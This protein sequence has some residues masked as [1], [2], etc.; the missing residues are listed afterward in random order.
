MSTAE[1]DDEAQQILD[2]YLSSLE[3]MA[4]GDIDPAD[5]N[6]RIDLVPGDPD[7]ESLQRSIKEF[8]QLEPLIWNRATRRLVG[9]HQRLTVLKHLKRTHAVVFVIDT[10]DEEREKALNLAL[11]KAVGRW[12]PEKLMAMVDTMSP[13]MLRLGG[14][15]SAD[16]AYEL[17]RAVEAGES[18]NFL[19]DIIRG[20]G[21]DADDREESGQGEPPERTRKREIDLKD[22]HAHRTGIQYF[23]VILQLTAEQRAIYY[24]AV[25][26][27]KKKFSTD[28]TFEAVVYILDAFNKQWDAENPGETVNDDLS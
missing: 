10:D 20:A 5:Y 12:D 6:P 24:Q 18:T 23:D 15:D 22:D 7:F 14:F 16:E 27:A 28:N 2:E 9:G 3:V 8:N 4:V 13:D 1:R 26:R 21:F 17:M 25:N 11:N 19:D